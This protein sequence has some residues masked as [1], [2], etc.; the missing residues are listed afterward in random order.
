MQPRLMLDEIL[1]DG[2]GSVRR[3]IVDYKNLDA[4][5]LL[6][7]GS[8]EPRDVLALVV[9][10]DDDKGSFSHPAKLTLAVDPAQA[11]GCCSGYFPNFWPAGADNSDDQQDHTGEERK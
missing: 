4:S 1:D 8:N 5:V 11:S 6:E 7:G 2:A 3:S 9:R 10:R